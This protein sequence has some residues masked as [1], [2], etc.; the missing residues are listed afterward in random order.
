M[1]PP[2]KGEK[3]LVKVEKQMTF[4]KVLTLWKMIKPLAKNVRDISKKLSA[5]SKIKRHFANSTTKNLLASSL[6]TSRRGDFT[7]IV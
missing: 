1:K 7:Q 6:E 2:V 5:G 4:E 3:T